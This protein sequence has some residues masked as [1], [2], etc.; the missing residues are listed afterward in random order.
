MDVAG[1]AC[2]CT[3]PADMKCARALNVWH[4]PNVGCCTKPT[5]ILADLLDDI[6]AAGSGDKKWAACTSR[7]EHCNP[8]QQMRQIRKALL[9]ASQSGGS[10]FTWQPYTPQGQTRDDI[11]HKHLFK[12]DWLEVNCSITA[13]RNALEKHCNICRQWLLALIFEVLFLPQSGG[14]VTLSPQVQRHHVLIHGPK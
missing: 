3:E 7:S 8:N 4:V 1:A 12:R 13:I 6:W 11:A 9:S 5:Y 2:C 14:G 10:A